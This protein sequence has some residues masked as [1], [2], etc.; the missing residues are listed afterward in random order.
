MV[1][2]PPSPSIAFSIPREGK[3][4]L[5]LA[6]VGID[7]LL[8]HEETI[9]QMLDVLTKQIEEEGILEDPVIVDRE[10]FVVLDGMHRVKAL[11]RLGCKLTPV[12]LVDYNS[13]EIKVERWCRTAKN[14]K[15]A[16]KL[17]KYIEAKGF[18]VKATPINEAER[19]LKAKKSIG[20]LEVKAGGYAILSGGDVDILSSFRAIGEVEGDLRSK[21]FKV[22]YETKEDAE[23]K[24][25]GGAVDALILPPKIEKRE[26]IEAAMRGEVFIPKSTR[27]IIPAR[28]LG[29]GIPLSLLRAEKLSPEEAEKACSK[30][31]KERTCRRVPPGSLW[32]G[33]R[34]DEELYVFE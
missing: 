24:L 15:K 16:E 1:D 12:C 13:P 8:L 17:I 11:R 2:D 23:K 26:V 31:L 25:S 5:D 9:P 27:H 29:I 20:L 19:L 14:E 22:E 18:K 33:R 21:G 28:P 30:L 3:M 7:R 34:Y 6:F 32:K 4:C 10:T